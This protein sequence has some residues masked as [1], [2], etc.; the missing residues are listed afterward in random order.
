[1]TATEEIRQLWLTTTPENI[2]DHLQRA[3]ALASDAGE[4]GGYIEGL[5]MLFLSYDPSEP[6]SEPEESEQRR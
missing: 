2:R 5:T 3:V 1:M 6:F 4:D